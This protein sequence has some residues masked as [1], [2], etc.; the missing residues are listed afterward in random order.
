MATRVPVELQVRRIIYERFNDIESKFTNDEVFEELRAG[1]DVD[2]DWIID[3][4]EPVIGGIC[5]SGMA[6]NIAQNFTTIWLKLNAPVERRGCAACG[7]D[8]FV[9]GAEDPV[10]PNPACKSAL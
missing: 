2:P 3:D 10:C 7:M 9:G 4:L 5:K 8:A 1:G 6:R